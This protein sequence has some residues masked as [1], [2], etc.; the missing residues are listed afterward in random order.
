MKSLSPPKNLWVVGTQYM[1]ISAVISGGWFNFSPP[2]V[3]P[4]GDDGMGAEER[5]KE[6]GR[7]DE[8]NASCPLT[9][10]VVAD[11]IK[12]YKLRASDFSRE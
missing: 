7:S 12:I 11:H 5:A 6:H 10:R 2:P 4:G 3:T 8:R 9:T 1:A